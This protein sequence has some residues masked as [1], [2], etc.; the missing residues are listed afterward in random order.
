MARTMVSKGADGDLVP[1]LRGILTQSLVKAGL[2]FDDAY[3]MAQ[4]VR[5]ELKDVAE[6]SS[7][8]LRDRVAELLDEQFGQ[9]L[10]DLYR[11]KP[12]AES[13]ILVNTPVRSEAFSVGV[14]SRSLGACAIEPSAALLAAHA[15][16]AALKRSRRKEIDH[17]SLRRIIYRC[18]REV[19]SPKLADRYLSWRRFENSG[20][21]LIILL[22]GVT[23]SG[24]STI[25]T[26]LS[27]RLDIARTQS[28]DMIREIIRSYITLEVAPTLKYSSFEAWRGLPHPKKTDEIDDPV[29]TGF[30]SQF[31]VV[32]PALDAAVAR[33]SLE[34]ERLIL[35]GVHVVPTELDLEAAAETGIVLPV[36]IAV[37]KKKTLR[38]RL[39]RRARENLQRDAQKYLDHI[40]E[41]WELQSYLLSAADAAGIAIIQNLHLETTIQELLEVLSRMIT[42]RF[43]ANPKKMD[44]EA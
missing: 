16:H 11:T 5:A 23:G 33:A 4:A 13:D 38:L 12:A 40:D 44:W 26:Q 6:I 27:Y 8:R 2:S 21:P 7:D 31:N 25:S 32:K 15:V 17:K 42:R 10:S 39:K 37:T 3:G 43:P 34:R 1:F 14:L 22:G 30:L 9:E 20:E 19:C 24:K 41:I 36:M 29:V 28:T 18:L 35:E